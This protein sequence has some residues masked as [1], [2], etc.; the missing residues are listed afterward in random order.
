MTQRPIE[1]NIILQHEETGRFTDR[2]FSYLDIF[3][4]TA[5]EELS[6]LNRWF[7][8]VVRSWTGLYDKNEKKV[9]EGDIVSNHPATKSY[10][11]VYWNN[12]RWGLR[13]GSWDYDNGDYYR[14]DDIT[15]SDFEVIGDI[16]QNS[17]LLSA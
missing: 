9:F 2:T 1:F 13:N 15:W 6:K 14:G 12:D 5:K 3:N 7:V 11:E 16:Y 17:D 4:G 10:Y 8:V